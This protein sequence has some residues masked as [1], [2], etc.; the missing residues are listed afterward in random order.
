MKPRILRDRYLLQHEIGAGGLG[1]VHLGLSLAEGGPGRRVAVRRLRPCYAHDRT[2]R[3]LFVDEAR[4]AGRLAHPNVAAMLEVAFEGGDLFLVTEYV[5]GETIA[6]LVRA[7]RG[8]APAGVAIAL[9][10]DALRGLHAIHEARGPDGGPLSLVHG[11]VTPRTVIA[12]LDGAARVLDFGVARPAT[13]ADETRNED[14]GDRVAYMAPERLLLGESTRSGDV[15]G[16]GLVL[17]EALTGRRVREG[18]SAAD[19]IVQAIEGDVTAPSQFAPGVPPALDRVVRTACAREPSARYA[20]ALEMAEA[21]EAACPR[22]TPAEVG[23]WV[24]RLAGEA[25]ERRGAP[26]PNATSE[27]D[28]ARA[29]APGPRDPE[30]DVTVLVP[31]PAVIDCGSRPPPSRAAA[32]AWFDPSESPAPDGPWHDRDANS[33]AGVH[34]DADD[35]PPVGPAGFAAADAPS[36][37]RAEATALRA[38]AAVATLVAVMASAA[39]LGGAS[40][41]PG[42]TTSPAAPGLRRADAAPPGAQASPQA[43]RGREATSAPPPVRP[44][45]AADVTPPAPAPAA[46]GAPAAAPFAEPPPAPPA[47]PAAEPPPGPPPAASALGAATLVATTAPRPPVKKRPKPAAPAS[48]APPPADAPDPPAPVVTEG[49]RRLDLETFDGA[50]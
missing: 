46:F 3:E 17:W 43:A 35:P 4:R 26:G 1:A 32:T 33:L 44:A 31:F 28:T 5:A 27:R 10:A 7:G 12:G 40:A 16:A 13:D 22:A 48:N 14:R 20:T 39:L 29:P 30:G 21:L 2:L 41:R 36:R 38:L 15:Y 6:G 37:P 49:A 34:C 18:T 8:G 25:I 47:A 50:E 11:D 23:A 42:V 19:F 45:P 9:A 24:K